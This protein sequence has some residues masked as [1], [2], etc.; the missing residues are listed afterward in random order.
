MRRCDA[1]LTRDLHLICRHEPNINDT[2]NAWDLFPDKAATY[3]I[4][5][6]S[7]AGIFAHDLTLAEVKQLRARQRLTFRDQAHNDQY[8]ASRRPQA[9]SCTR[10]QGPSQAPGSQPGRRLPG[11]AA[12]AAAAGAHL[13]PPARCR[14]PRWRSS[15]RSL[16]PRREWWAS[17]QRSVG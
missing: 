17:T 8:Q 12:S 10:L 14:S 15:W 2:T 11:A 6:E 16:L 9:T 1:V 13:A 7:T 4:D 3:L 5:G